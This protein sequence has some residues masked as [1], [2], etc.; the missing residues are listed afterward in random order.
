MTPAVMINAGELDK[1]IRLRT[2]T[3]V[4]NSS[5]GYTTTPVDSNPFWAKVEPLTGR[6]LMVAMQTGIERP[7]RF[8]FRYADAPDIT[9]KAQ[10]LYDG[11]TFDI[12]SIIDPAEQHIKFEVLATEL[13]PETE[14]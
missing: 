13:P 1:Q 6:E 12:K 10:I 3:R 8:T 5:G 11:R 7:H 2:S 4:R 14:E 9:A